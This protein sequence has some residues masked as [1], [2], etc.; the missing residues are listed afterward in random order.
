[1]ET[2]KS[3]FCHNKLLMNHVA[4]LSSQLLREYYSVISYH[5]PAKI[6]VFTL[7]HPFFHFFPYFCKDPLPDL[8]F[9]VGHMHIHTL[10]I[11]LSLT[12]KSDMYLVMFFQQ[13]EA[14]VDLC[15]GSSARGTGPP[16]MPWWDCSAIV[17]KEGGQLGITASWSI[18]EWLHG[19]IFAFT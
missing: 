10:I 18:P 3:S 13:W 16:G 6:G 5:Q 8:F 12:L 14:E 1:M 2:Q 11:L 4:P 17:T 7:S 9:E 19:R 15:F